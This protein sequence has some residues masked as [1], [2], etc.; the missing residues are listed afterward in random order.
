MSDTSNAQDDS[1]LDVPTNDEDGAPKPGGLGDDSTIPNHP[2]G[3]A[4]GFS[5]TDS[6]FNHEEDPEH[7]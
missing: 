3:V 1:S 6:H 4:A 7:D 2:E 5:E